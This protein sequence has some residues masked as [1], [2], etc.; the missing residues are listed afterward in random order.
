M[1]QK[2]IA[3]GVFRKEVDISEVVV[4]AG[5]SIGAMVGKAHKGIVN[6]RVL[7]TTDQDFYETFGTPVSG[8]SS[9]N[10]YYAAPAFLQESSFLYFVRPSFGNEQYAN[11]AINSNSLVT[12]SSF[13]VGAFGYTS[14]SSSAAAVDYV[15]NQLS[16]DV[17]Q[18]ASTTI[19]PLDPGLLFAQ[20]G[21]EDGNK[22]NN[23]YDIDNSSLGLLQVISAVDT[24][25]TSGVSA[26]AEFDEAL[27][28]ASIGPG[29]YGDDIGVAIITTA[30]EVR[31]DL[32][33]W[34]YTFD[35]PTI[36]GT[37]SLPS[38]ATDAIWKSVYKVKLYTKSEGADPIVWADNGGISATPVEEFLVSNNP[39]LKNAGG[40][41]LYAPDVINGISNYVYVNPSDFKYPEAMTSVSALANGAND[42]ANTPSE[43]VAA[44][45]LFASRDRV[46]VNILIPPD[47]GATER[48]PVFNKVAQLCNARLDCIGVAQVGP[49]TITKPTSLVDF[50]NG[51]GYAYPAPSYMANY[52]G[53]D[54]I[55]DSFTDKNIYV[56]KSIYGATLMARTDRVSDTWQA[57][58]GINRGVIP[59]IGQNIVFTEAELG[60]LYDNNINT[61][62]LIRNTGNVMW[63]Q[64][65]A[66]RKASALDRI[67]VRRL[68]LYVE[69]SVEPSLLP[70]VFELN[71]EA[72]RS[73]A[74]A[75]VNS[76]MS[77]VR[78]AGGVTDYQ[79]VVDETNNTAQVIDNNQ[80]NVSIFV[81]PTKVIEFIEL[82]VIITRTGVSFA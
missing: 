38:T 73:R 19:N 79:V 70:F 57:P 9:E 10:A 65:T 82:T 24:P 75:I 69:N 14:S 7:V 33:D 68:L 2:F 50:L 23:I 77:T 67:N 60:Y 66:Q 20:D 29:T 16:A 1:A 28:V 76:F 41:T 40:G 31:E 56:P 27:I 12:S 55:Y 15:I 43:T 18:P 37:S 58:A 49:Q 36:V 74:F 5:T 35:D 39:N 22:V 54:Q 30:S 53:Y 45:D 25:P 21:F 17:N 4:P 3:P 80:L 6:S 34:G 8:L 61:S 46:S 52:A 81:Q 78:S 59:S 72:T 51:N 26:T 44:W 63:G 62:K 48:V 64:K 42:A 11:I 32:F 13:T 71:T 47:E